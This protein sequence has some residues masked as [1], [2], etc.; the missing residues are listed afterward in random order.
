M[1]CFPSCFVAC[2]NPDNCNVYLYPIVLFGSVPT[3]AVNGWIFV[4]VFVTLDASS[5][6]INTWIFDVFVVVIAD[7]VKYLSVI[8]NT[9]VC[10]FAVV[11]TD[12]LTLIISGFNVS[13]FPK[14]IDNY[15]FLLP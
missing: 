14:S 3:A 15:W 13:I 11:S 7:E 4:I 10:V 2:S 9:I 12:E 1:N 5:P 6:F 8:S